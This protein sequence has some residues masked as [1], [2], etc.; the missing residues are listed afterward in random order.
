MFLGSSVGWAVPIPRV[1]GL[2]PVPPKGELILDPLTSIDVWARVM[3]DH[4]STSV[5]VSWG[6][7]RARGISKGSKEHSGIGTRAR[8]GASARIG[9]SRRDVAT[10][11]TASPQR[12]DCSR[13][14]RLRQGS[15]LEGARQVHPRRFAMRVTNVG[16][17]TSRRYAHSSP[18]GSTAATVAPDR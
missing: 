18:R 8:G 3:P 9:R 10:L 5:D 15:R 12:G 11:R 16:S 7:H 14:H 13:S 6:A 2:A 4:I 1:G 17:T